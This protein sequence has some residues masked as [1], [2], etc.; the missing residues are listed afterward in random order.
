M[1]RGELWGEGASHC[2]C[3]VNSNRGLC[4]LRGVPAAWTSCWATT[5]IRRGPRPSEQPHRLRA[6]RREGCDQLISGH[7]HGFGGLA[8]VYETHLEE[9]T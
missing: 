1:W 3:H 7:F 2:M 8:F 4:T 5:Q 6:Q 9:I